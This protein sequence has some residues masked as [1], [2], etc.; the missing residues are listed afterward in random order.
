MQL[1]ALDL[2]LGYLVAYQGRMCTVSHWNIL[3]NDRRQFVQLKLKDLATGRITE[4]KE[5]GET[6]YEV[7]DKEEVDLSHS[8]RDGQEEVFYKKDG[9]E[10]RCAITAAE[11][12]L[13]W[14]SDTYKGF[15]VN[16]LLVSVL[17]PKHSVLEIK[18]T[19][20]PIR[21][22]GTGQK[23]ALLENGMKV[24][25]GPLCDVGDKVRVETETLEFR[26]RF[27]K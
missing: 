23:D 21:G 10:V 7:L 9:E 25:V 5:H 13:Q 3:R 20:P 27:A 15:F 8:Y 1:S 19:A 18:E 14:P 2:R 6:K 16:G 11:D 24:K 22:G 4:I 26:E 17:P 12:A